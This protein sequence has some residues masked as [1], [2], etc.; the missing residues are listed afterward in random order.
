MDLKRK[1]ARLGGIGPGG[2]PGTKPSPDPEAPAAEVSAAPPVEVP[3]APV[4]VETP[5]AAEPRTTPHGLIH[6]AE[7]VLPADHHHGNAPLAEALDVES[8]LVAS[9]ALQPGLA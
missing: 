1:L 7:R 2:K 8:P 5:P 4:P 3:P 9:L 6:V